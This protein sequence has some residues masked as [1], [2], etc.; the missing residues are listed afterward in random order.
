MQR[1][2]D[3]NK[4]TGTR[5]QR[6]VKKIQE[7]RDKDKEIETRIKRRNKEKTHGDR[8]KETKIGKQRRRNKDKETETRRQ[9]QG[10]KKTGTEIRRKMQATETQVFGE[11][12]RHTVGAVIR[13][14]T[15]VKV[16]AHLFYST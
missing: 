9:S 7:Y 4:K 11:T 8:D 12:R 16:A 1:Q 14:A 6:K 5:K 3:R 15:K 10:D 13:V 2:G